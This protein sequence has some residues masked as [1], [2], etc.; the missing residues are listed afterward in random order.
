M[1]PLVSTAPCFFALACHC[2]VGAR[3]DF[4]EGRERERGV[5]KCRE[6]ATE[7]A[8]SVE[9]FSSPFVVQPCDLIFVAK[10]QKSRTKMNG[11]RRDRARLNSRSF[12]TTSPADGTV[13]LREGRRKSFTRGQKTSHK[14]LPLLLRRSRPVPSNYVSGKQRSSHERRSVRS[15]VLD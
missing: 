13:S 15:M 14:Y 2:E 6:R 8:R 10:N 7:R 3:S 12:A 4:D 5:R 9:I 11:G 1:I